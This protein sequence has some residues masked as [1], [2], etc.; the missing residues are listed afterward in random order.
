MHQCVSLSISN[1]LKKLVICGSVLTNFTDFLLNLA[2]S[3]T[4]SSVVIQLSAV[5]KN[6]SLSFS[7]LALAFCVL[8]CNVFFSLP[9][10]ICLF[11]REDGVSTSML[12]GV[13]CA[14]F[15]F[16][17]ILFWVI[18]SLSSYSTNFTAELVQACRNEELVNKFLL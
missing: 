11:L 6:R 12:S 16:S 18:T 13:P 4:P 5:V 17:H 10:R 2:T 8:L 14:I 1:M 7:V 15:V 3:F 9:H